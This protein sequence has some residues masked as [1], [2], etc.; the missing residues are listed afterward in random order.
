M[1][2]N[3]AFRKQ[4]PRDDAAAAPAGFT[5]IE[6]LVVIAIIA[7]LAA[8][9]LPVL[10]QA[11]ER[12]KR[13]S[14]LNN[15]KQ[16]GFALVMYAGE[17]NDSVPVPDY[18]ATSSGTG[19]PWKA[20]NL[21]E[22]AGAANGG[23]VDFTATPP[24]NHGLFYTT[25]LISAGKTFY[26]PSMSSVIPEQF[27]YAYENYANATRMWPVYGV[28]A[29]WTPYCRSSYMYYPQ[30][31]QLMIAGVP[32]SGYQE[33]KKLGQLDS[34]HVAMTDLIYDYPSIPHRSG[35]T[36]TALNILWGDGHVK[37]STSPAAFNYSYWGSNPGG[38]GGGNDAADNEPQFLKIISLLQ[39]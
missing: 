12:A 39:P 7:I 13:I 33:A 24:V 10:S 14:C 6:L 9:L 27:K 32:T 28:N 4:K 34:Q 17:N 3:F 38:Q 31:S 23:A 30:T 21:V 18:T 5:L 2:V 26:C 35:S 25:K 8:L 15:M 20:Y 22:P 29:T 1:T 36:A 19:S 11:K 16:M 37:I